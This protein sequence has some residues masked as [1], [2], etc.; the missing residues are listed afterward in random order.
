MQEPAQ[1]PSPT[2]APPAEPIAPIAPVAPIGINTTPGATPAAVFEALKAQR[3]ELRNQLESLE[4]KR[5]DLS[6]RL[7]DPMVGGADRKGLE[8][9]IADIDQR[10][11][12][13][14]K[15]IGESE[16]KIA[17]AAAV[18]GAVQ[19]HRVPPREGPPEAVFVLAGIFMVVVLFPLAI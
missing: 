12:L 17:Q 13:V 2:P 3:S 16:L 19:P 10:I 18:P 8:A 6:E 15:Q 11:T 7:Q 14:D 4:D 9:R 1:S 5:R